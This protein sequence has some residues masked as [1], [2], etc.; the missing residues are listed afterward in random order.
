MTTTCTCGCCDGVAASTPTAV[1][2]RPGLDT[3]AYRSG[4]HATI[5]AS[6]VAGLTDVDRPALGGLTTRADDDF[7]IGLLDAF[8]VMGDVLTFYNERLVQD[9][10]LRTATDLQALRELG[11]LLGHRPAP[12]AAAE[13][14]LAFAV[15]PPPATPDGAGQAPGSAPPVTPTE[16]QMPAGLRVQ[17]IPGPDE[18]PQIFETVEAITASAARNALPAATTQPQVLAKGDTTAWF[19][20]SDLGLAAGDTLLVEAAGGAW[21]LLAV[22]I[23]ATDPVTATTKVTWSEQLWAAEAATPAGTPTLAMMQARHRVFAHNAPMWGAMGSDFQNDYP[24]G[25]SSS[26]DWPHHHITEHVSAPP[27]ALYD[28]VD[29][30]ATDRAIAPE[31]TVVLVSPTDTARFTVDSVEHRSRAEFA[32]SGEVTRVH[33]DDSA[34]ELSAFWNQVRALVVLARPQPLVLTDRPASTAVAAS[35]TTLVVAGDA[36]GLAEDTT[37]IVAGPTYADPAERHA[38]ATTVVA[39]VELADDRWEV[40]VADPVGVALLRDGLVLHGNVARATHGETV[41]ELL[42]SGDGRVAFARHRLSRGPVTHVLG[43]SDGGVTS[44]LQVRVN[45]VAWQEVATQYESRPDDR[46]HVTDRP[47]VAAGGDEDPPTEVVFGDGVRGARVPTG[48]NNVR[49]TYRVGLGSAGNVG[50]GALAQLLDRPLGLSGVTNPLP[51]SGG[52]DPD[53]PEDARRTIP[54]PVRTLGRAVSLLDYADFALARVGIA[55]ATATVLPLRGGRTIVVTVATTPD[56]GDATSL[57]A[58]LRD[59]LR[60]FG[61]PL[62]PI[63]VVDHRHDEV[64][65]LGTAVVHPD[66][67]R[68]VVQAALDA[69]LAGALAFDARDLLAPVHRSELVAVA[70]TVPGVVAIDIDAMSSPTLPGGPAATRILPR[71]P[72]VTPQGQPLAAGLLLG[73]TVAVTAIAQA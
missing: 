25:S 11:R 6:L 28:A 63:A 61:D 8:A 72:G 40:E 35:T 3:V 32:I 52:T 59:D 18:L 57:L 53:G 43:G 23:V 51:A 12:G 62:T 33:L 55:K 58:A 50:P 9:A 48:V 56:S 21:Q 65:V 66:H 27:S 60:A 73:G 34:N 42:G 45:D 15:Q 26:P 7:A 44:T 37:V 70:H 30:A 24:D 16:V 2:N 17:S 41:G 36:S 22:T 31:S 64:D 1:A 47:P 38:R 69:A 71:Q 54:L 67:D 10:W 13:A 4:T 5:L 20:G 29:L 14:L 39:T 68:E 19:A 49:A 46:T